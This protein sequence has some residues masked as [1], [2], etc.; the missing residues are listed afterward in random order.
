MQ[1]CV[2]S[3]VPGLSVFT[4]RLNYFAGEE[5]NKKRHV[6][7]ERP[8]IKSSSVYCMIMGKLMCIN[9]WVRLRG[10]IAIFCVHANS[11]FPCESGPLPMIPA[12]PQTADRW[13]SGS[14]CA[15]LAAGCSKR[16]HKHTQ[17]IIIHCTCR[18]S[19][20]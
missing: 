13:L 12:P 14:R 18:L 6:N 17:I 4:C 1:L 3:L 19:I 2:V 5:A 9:N 11:H 20:N 16:R 10:P 7:T 15:A 8:G